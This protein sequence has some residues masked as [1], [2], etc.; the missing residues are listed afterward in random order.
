MGIPLGT[1]QSRLHYSLASMRASVIEHPA[2]AAAPLP[3]GTP[4]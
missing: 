2:S 3:E 1:A 4:A